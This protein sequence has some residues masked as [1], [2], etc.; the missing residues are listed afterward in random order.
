MEASD[1]LDLIGTIEDND[2]GEPNMTEEDSDEEV[3]AYATFCTC[4]TNKRRDCLL[5]IYNY[6]RRLNTSVFI[7]MAADTTHG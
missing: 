2:D 3:S 6:D 5:N 1:D 4:R 7:H